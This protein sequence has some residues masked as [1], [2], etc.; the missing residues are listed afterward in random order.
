MPPLSKLAF[1]LFH[2]W[3]K[4]EE[5]EALKRDL[6]RARMGVSVEVYVSISLLYSLLV[7]LSLILFFSILGLLG[8]FSPLGVTVGILLS[9]GFWM[10]LYRLFLLIPGFI[11]K[12]RAYKI[13]L[14]LPQTIGFMYALSRGG[15]G[16][17]EIFRE[18]SR[19]EDAGELRNEAK[20]FMRDVEQLGQDP[21]TALRN[22]AQSTPSERFREL[23]DVLA[24]VIESGGDL[25]SYFSSKW[26]E[27]QRNAEADHSKLISS[28]ELYSEL[29][30]NL[31]I[32]F[33]LVMLILFSLLGPLGGYSD[34]WLYLIAYAVVPAVASFF[35][36][37]VSLALPGR[38]PMSRHWGRL[39]EEY[40]GV[41][42]VEEK[43]EIKRISLPRRLLKWVWQ[44]VR[45]PVEAV[46]RQPATSFFFSIPLTS[47]V[48][49]F[50]RRN[51]GIE[52]SSCFILGFL[53]VLG[54]YSLVYEVKRAKIG[55]LEGSLL[56]FL[57]ALASGIK[58]GLTLSASL[59]VTSSADL[60]PFTRETKK[61]KRDLSWGISAK[62]ALERFE[63]R[64]ADSGDIVYVTRVIEKSSETDEDISG[65]LDILMLDVA[66]K[67]ELRKKRE[68][69]LGS[70]KII[71]LMM[72]GLFLFSTFMVVSSVM[73]VNR[74]VGETAFSYAAN[75]STIRN[76]FMHAAMIEGFFAGLL[77]GQTSSGDLRAGLKYSV[78]L[79]LVAFSLFS[80]FLKV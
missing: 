44:L 25:P 57:R 55:Y 73:S 33:P 12:N 8:R 15:A 74:E 13:N 68:A 4:R 19:Y 53:A 41:P 49:F 9:L 23:L 42:L 58:S 3:V 29:Y 1:R 40:T 27:Y 17:V 5:Q 18:L 38:L 35:L 79:M 69:A 76:L 6:K 78:V 10:A 48:L 56:D 52:L 51:L 75:V 77:V 34:L 36:V 37:M 47:L 43:A 31:V 2:R 7:S 72:F 30:V 66:N 28:L 46:S 20:L 32:L 70:Y 60:G 64:V 65:V 59:K 54:F 21:L 71:V 16:V 26:M 62:E 39:R 63:K 80:L 24:S 61:M 45:K 50:L 67:Q 11:A 22:L 14:A